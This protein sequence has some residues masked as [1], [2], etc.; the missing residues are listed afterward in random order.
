MS[1]IP[2]EELEHHRKEFEISLIFNEFKLLSGNGGELVKNPSGEYA[3]VFIEAAWRGYQMS[4]SHA[5]GMLERFDPMRY[6]GPGLEGAFRELSDFEHP[7][8]TGVDPLYIHDLIRS[9]LTACKDT[10]V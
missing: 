8:G 3:N 1:N 9:A 7:D 5:Y 6:I 4:I 2:P 10:P